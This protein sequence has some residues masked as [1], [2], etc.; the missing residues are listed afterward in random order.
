MKVLWLCNIMLPAIAAQLNK[1]FSEKEGWLS[2]CLDGLYSID[3][4]KDVKLAVAFPYN[5]PLQ[6]DV[7]YKGRLLR[8][9]GFCEDTVHPYLYSDS[10]EDAFRGIIKD[11]EPDV[12]HCFGTEYPHTLAMC[13]AAANK[14][15]LLI[16]IQGVMELYTKAYDASLPQSVLGSQTFRDILKKDSLKEQHLKFFLRGL[17]EIEAVKLSGNFTGRTSFDRNFVQSHHPDAKYYFMNETLRETFYTGMDTDKLSHEGFN[18]IVSQCDYPIKGLHYMLRALYDIKREIPNVKLMVAGNKVTDYETIK[19]KIK[20]SAYGRYLRQL[21]KKYDLFENIEF[22]GRLNSNAMREA[23]QKADLYVCCSAIE[24][25][26]N[27]LGEAMLL[28]VPC[29]TAD[30]GGITSIFESGKDGI[31]YRGLDLNNPYEEGGFERISGELANAV[32]YAYRNP[33]Y[34]KECA[35]NAYRH[36][37]KTHNPRENFNTLLEIYRDITARTGGYKCS[38]SDNLNIS[39]TFVSNYINHH[40][41]PLSNALKQIYGERYKFVQCEPMEEERKALGWQ[42]PDLDYVEYFYEN[43]EKCRKLIM[44]SSMVIFGG[45]DDESVI[46]PRL[47]AGKPVLRYTERVYKEAQW[48][49]ISPRGLIKKYGDHTKYNNSNV[50]L[51]CSG[52]YVA[53]DFNIFKAYPGKRYKWGYFPEFVPCDVDKCLDKKGMDGKLY[54]LWAARFID[55]KHPEIAISVA[56]RLKREGIDFVMEMAGNGPLYDKVKADV[57]KKDLSKYVLLPGACEPE[58][59]REK[60]LKADIFLMTSDRGEGWGAVLNESMNSCCAVCCNKMAGAV[61]FMVR[62]GINGV[63]Y[64]DAYAEKLPEY[65]L[66]LANDRNL[67]HTLSRNAYNT[68]ALLWNADIAA[69]RVAGLIKEMLSD[70]S[71]VKTVFCDGPCSPAPV[72]S[73]KWKVEEFNVE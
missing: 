52:A 68:V 59:I 22:L 32:L 47:D 12:I 21:M 57:L 10:L 35:E 4:A 54:I 69:K 45:L 60:M 70:K 44:D 53:S 37:V 65:V 72:L 39:V 50:R 43:P 16:G 6:T 23:F 28:K 29:V 36:A 66:K 51:L 20:I 19:D 56:E 71:S 31:V 15:S 46:K 34:M 8:A 33:A 30:V 11:F 5:N 73:E 27:S 3:E 40:Q 55:W 38:A 48:K 9:Y 58:K 61:P 18:I 2:G 7:Y 26:P 25:S 17:N 67:R 62:Q 63:I 14:D 49:A 24:N 1:D 13:R 41:I 42:T 64:T